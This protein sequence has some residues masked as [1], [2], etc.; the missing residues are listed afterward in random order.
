MTNATIEPVRAVFAFLLG[1]TAL[2][3][4]PVNAQGLECPTIEGGVVAALDAG[5]SQI[6]R[7]TTSNDVDLANEI[8]GLIRR[9]KAESPR[10]SNDAITNIL[11]GAYCQIVAKSAS[12]SPAEKW[13]LMR[14]FDRVVMQQIAANTMPPESTVIANIPL[15]P[16]VYQNLSNQAKASGQETV[17]FM[18]AVLTS[19]TRQ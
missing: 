5:D 11:I 3:P 14:R 2:M 10:V 1:V 19:A 15:A 9:L 12:V 16:S 13:Q 7:M 4:V 17:D 6:Q 8:G 18:A